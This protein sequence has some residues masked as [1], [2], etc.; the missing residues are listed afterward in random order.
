MKTYTKLR[1][2]YGKLTKNESAANLAIGDELMNDDYRLTCAMEDWHFLHR[3]R[4]ATTVG[5][6]Q[7]V[8]LPYDIEQ[9]EQV[10]VTVGSTRYVA[11]P[12]FTRED[13]DRLNE[14]TFY[15]DNLEKFF[16][17]NGKLEQW[18]IPASS[19]NTISISGKIQVQDLVI[20]DIT[21]FTVQSLT[22]GSTSV[23]L[24][25]GTF[26]SQMTGLVMCVT[27]GTQ[28]NTGDGRWYEISSVTSG[29]Q[30]VLT[31]PYGGVSIAAATAACTIGQAPLLPEFAQNASVYAAA[32]IY[33]DKEGDSE[34]A[35][36]MEAI[37]NKKLN[38]LITQ[39]TSPIT[40]SVVDT[41]EDDIELNP[42]LTITM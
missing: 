13:W 8:D 7:S 34:R 21:S 22:N 24:A 19:G 26:T 23:V 17:Y 5:S 33:W 20:P 1:T 42:N 16:I 3:L 27:A 14:S 40:S 29:T 36:R 37:H 39:H 10:Y 25:S 28:A 2:L 41:G 15:S 38:W 12:V 35:L 31:R 4:T 11:D 32:A 6:I 9:V 30:A 18:P